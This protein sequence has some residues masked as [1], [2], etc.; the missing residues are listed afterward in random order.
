MRYVVE[1]VSLYYTL[2]A[3]VSKLLPA[4]HRMLIIRAI[5][6]MRINRQCLFLCYTANPLHKS[7][8][9]I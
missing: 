8:W 1:F 2:H 6:G 5:S 3:H 9:Q 7:G 4:L